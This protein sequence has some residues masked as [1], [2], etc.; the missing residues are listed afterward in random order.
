MSVLS[1]F[2]ETFRYILQPIAPFTWFGTSISTLDVVATLRLCIVLRQIRDMQIAQHK[3]LKKDV[4]VE[5]YS[6]VKNLATTLLVV[7]G[8]EAITGPFLGLTP[9]FMLSGVVPVLYAAGQAIADNLPY[10]PGPS[11]QLEFPLSVV[12]GFTRAYLLCNLIPPSVTTSNSPLIASSPWTL[13][14]TSL[15]TA[16]AGFFLTNLFSF[17][18]PTSMTVQTPPELQAYGWTTTDLWC[19]P[20]TTALYAFLTHAQPFWAELHLV[21]SQVL[22]STS[23]K[24]TVEPLDPESAR[25]VCA[26]FLMTLFTTRTAHNFGLLKNINWKKEPKLKTQ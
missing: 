19:A 11:A 18:N 6:F 14:I 1:P 21:L 3:S 9:S 13:L 12:D 23:L 5:P 8:G 16:N 15:I 7:Y 26:L 10:V 2:I 17:L 20:V 22:G 24:G 25:A 4:P